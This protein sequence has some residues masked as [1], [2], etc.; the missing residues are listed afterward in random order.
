MKT[1]NLT[2]KLLALLAL[3]VVTLQPL[4]AHAQGTAFNY[5]GQL[6][7]SGKPAN[8][9]YDLR[10]TIYD[11]PNVPGNIIGGPVTNSATT[12]SNGQFS[13]LLDFGSG[14]FT[15]PGR[16]VQLD[17]ETN[18]AGG[19]FTSLSPRQQVLPMPY[20]LMSNSASNLLGTL[21]TAQLSGTV[22]LAQLPAAVLTNNDSG[23]NLSGTF[24]GTVN[25]GTL[26]VSTLNS[27]GTVSGASAQFYSM[28]FLTAPP[29][30]NTNFPYP[31]VNA[32]FFGANGTFPQGEAAITNYMNFALSQGYTNFGVGTLL[33]IDDG[34]QSTNGAI[35]TGSTWSRGSHL[36][37]WNTNLFPDG[38]PFLCQTAHMLGF[39]MFI[40]TQP[41][42]VTA[43]GLPGGADGSGL[44]GTNIINDISN[45]VNWG[46]DGIR[47]DGEDFIGTPYTAPYFDAYQT[48]WNY[49]YTNWTRF[50]TKAPYLQGS[51]IFPLLYSPS[52]VQTC[53][54]SVTNYGGDGAGWLESVNEFW[55]YAQLGAEIA[56]GHWPLLQGGVAGPLPNS[57][58]GPFVLDA[59]LPGVGQ[60]WDGQPP[61]AMTN[62]ALLNIWRD[63][64]CS[65]AWLVSSNASGMVYARNLTNQDLAV[66]LLNNNAENPTSLGFALSQLGFPTTTASIYA[67]DVLA[68]TNFTI[69]PGQG[70]TNSSVP[71]ASPMLL[72]LS[73]SGDTWT[74]VT[75]LPYI[76][77]RQILTSLLPGIN[78]AIAVQTNSIGPHGLY[79]WL[80]GGVITN[81]TAY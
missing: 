1:H 38:I 37:F 31:P 26:S 59:M 17:V 12:V 58:N 32:L 27:A 80:G 81:V 30:L 67:Q 69:P 33:D 13:V 3:A 22:P 28:P 52:A 66:M 44:L 46:L 71:C 21:T 34:W 45:Y 68:G 2:V 50:S 60:L 11:S 48:N 6:N 24:S 55:Q 40:Y 42:L 57:T 39:K 63:P 25:A 9:L 65:P 14:V 74:G 4:T 72:R 75:N 76:P 29:V 49:V 77:P 10:F 43:A 70:F 5:Q 62:W 20:A 64:L 23:V 41:N 47:V 73:M 56:P 16:W 79:I 53:W 7:D 61:P 8:G 35:W 18:G 51:G 36:L 19:V 15:G 54:F 78:G